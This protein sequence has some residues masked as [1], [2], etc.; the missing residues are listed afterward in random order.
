M[1]QLHSNASDRETWNKGKRADQ[2][3]PLKPRTSGQAVFDCS[4][5]VASGAWHCSILPSIASC[6]RATSSS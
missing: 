3:S 4:F 1:E 2:K 6:E 5:S